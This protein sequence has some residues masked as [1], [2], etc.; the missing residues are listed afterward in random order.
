MGK[1]CQSAALAV[2]PWFVSALD[3]YINRVVYVL[4]VV[5]DLQTASLESLNSPNDFDY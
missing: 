2:W 3:P 5:H 1:Q 4:Q